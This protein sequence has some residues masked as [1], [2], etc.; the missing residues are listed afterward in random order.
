MKVDGRTGGKP[1]KIWIECI[2]EDVIEQGLCEEEATERK[3]W[4]RKIR[5]SDT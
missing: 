5:K 3:E 2:T 4:E 1:M